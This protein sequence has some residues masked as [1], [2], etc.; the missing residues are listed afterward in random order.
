VKPTYRGKQRNREEHKQTDR[1]KGDWQEHVRCRPADGV[2]RQH[3]TFHSCRCNVSSLSDTTLETPAYYRPCQTPSHPNTNTHRSHPEQRA[4]SSL[5]DIQLFKTAY[6]FIASLST[7]EKLHPHCDNFWYSF[8]TVDLGHPKEN[9]WKFQSKFFYRSEA[10][11]VIL[12]SN[13]GP[14]SVPTVTARVLCSSTWLSSGPAVV[15]FVQWRTSALF[16]QQH[17]YADG[18]QVYVSASVEELTTTARYP[19]ALMTS[20]TG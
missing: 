16:L 10:L 6:Y 14:V 4:E 7:T 11:S 3:D 2:Q 17:Q 8:S 5:T 18:C 15:Q 1:E 20:H 12:P 9:L 19:T 13:K